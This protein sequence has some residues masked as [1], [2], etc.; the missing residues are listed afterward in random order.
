[1][2]RRFRRRSGPRGALIP[3]P[4][5]GWRARSSGTSRALQESLCC[6]DSLARLRNAC[7]RGTLGSGLVSDLEGAPSAGLRL[8]DPD[9]GCHCGHLPAASRCSGEVP[10]LLVGPSECGDRTAGSGKDHRCPLP[11]SLQ[12]LPISDIWPPALGG[13]GRGSRRGRSFSGLAWSYRARR[14]GRA[15]T[16]ER[17]G[18]ARVHHAPPP[19]TATAGGAPAGCSGW[20]PRCGCAGRARAVRP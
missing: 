16:A 12:T 5:D 20:R 18:C 10:N 3:N 4:D 15:P 6:F 17:R 13:G 2:D 1:M 7:G 11:M 14:P 8:T 9:S 19:A